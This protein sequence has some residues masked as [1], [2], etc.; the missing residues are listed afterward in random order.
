MGPPSYI[1]SVVVRNVVM[2]RSPVIGEFRRM[3]Q[4]VALVCFEFVSRA[5]EV[6]SKTAKKHEDSLRSCGNSSKASSEYGRSNTAW[7]KRGL[8]RSPESGHEL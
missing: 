5:W 6:L 8:S 1:R 4:D 7:G 3:L 2:R